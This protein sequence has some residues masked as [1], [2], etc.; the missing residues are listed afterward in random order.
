MR[1]VHLLATKKG[2]LRASRWDAQN[3]HDKDS[4]ANSIRSMHLSAARR[5]SSRG[6]KVG[7]SSARSTTPRYVLMALSSLSLECSFS[8]SKSR[9]RAR[10]YK[11]RAELGCRY[12]IAPKE[13]KACSGF[14]VGQSKQVGL[15][16]AR[17]GIGGWGRRQGGLMTKARM[18]GC[19]KQWNRS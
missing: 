18:D 14:Y 7:C 11:A 8:A 1:S 5:K 9:Q 3:K 2:P 13:F 12:R 6:T 4:P 15:S 10:P 16:G 19:E 17:C